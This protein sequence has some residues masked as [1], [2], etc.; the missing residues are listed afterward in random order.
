MCPERLPCPKSESTHVCDTVIHLCAILLAIGI[1]AQSAAAHSTGAFDNQIKNNSLAVSPNEAIAVVSYSDEPNVLVYDLKS[2]TVRAKLTGFVTPRNIVFAPDGARFYI[3]DSGTGR[4]TSFNS[5]SLKP[6]GQLAAGPGVFGTT[7]SADGTKLYANNQAAS[8]VTVYDLKADK[9]HAVI[10]GFAQPRQGVRLG[11]DGKQLYVTNFLGDK[12]TLVDTAT[13]KIIGEIG[14]FDKI[15]AISIT[16]DGKKLYAANSGSNSIAIV[17]PETRKITDTVK[18]GEDPYGAALTSDGRFVYSGNLKGNSLSVID[19]ASAK[20]VATVTGL[21]E[22]R[23]AIV[24]SK[25]GSRAFVLNR[26]LSIA[27]VDRA[28]NTVAST[29]RAK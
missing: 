15:R 17:D 10:M 19:T 25:D 27:V 24:F 12:I 4:I 14:G 13:D 1:V 21:N 5:T 9:T 29:L 6:N 7:I 2:G 16:S 22:P 18:V 11:P 8:T 28:T 20:V 23:Q 26:D 3:S